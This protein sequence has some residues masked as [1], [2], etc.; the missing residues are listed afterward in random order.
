MNIYKR[1]TTILFVSN[2][3]PTLV[4]ENK[5]PLKIHK[6]INKYIS[7]YDMEKQRP[8]HIETKSEISYIFH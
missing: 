3:M 6:Y 8:L 4:G 5:H 7:I 1:C 2:F